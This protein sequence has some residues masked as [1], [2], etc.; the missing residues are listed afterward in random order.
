MIYFCAQKARRASVLEHPNL[1]GIDFLEV[2]LDHPTQLNVVF[3]KPD[4]LA[5]LQPVEFAISGGE[6]VSGI[7]AESLTI[8]PDMLNRAVVTVNEGG[9]FSTYTLTLRHLPAIGDPKV[10]GPPDGFDPALARIDFS[11]KAGCPTT[12]DCRI[13]NCCPV[14]A[15]SGPD[16][17]YLAKDFQGFRQVMLDR[18]WTL[19]PGWTEQHA[20][21]PGIALVEALAY[22]ADHLSYRHD[23]IGTESYL[24]TARSRISLRRHAR[25]VDYVVSDG[26]CAHTWLQIQ[27][28]LNSGSASLPINTPVFSRVSG[29]PG[30]VDPDSSDYPTLVKNSA[31]AFTTLAEKMCYELHNE[32]SFYTWSDTNCCLPAGAVEA[33]LCGTLSKLLVGDVLIFAEQFGPETGQQEDADPTHRWAVRLTGVRSTDYLG[34]VLTDPLTGTAVTYIEWGAADALPF[35]L[36]VSSTYDDGKAMTPLPNVSVAY[37]N[38][39]IARHGAQ[40]IG[41]WLGVVPAATG[42][43]VGTTLGYCCGTAAQTAPLPRYNPSLQHQP[44]S[45]AYP[46]DAGAAAST[47]TVPG[48]PSATLAPP[49][50]LIS[51][52]D[53]QK[54]PW[55]PQQTLLGMDE[56]TP[57]FVVEVE[58]DGT[59]FLRFGDGQSGAAALPNASFTAS[60]WTGNGTAGNVG[61]DTLIHLVSKTEAF[62]S[63]GNPLAAAGGVDPETM[64]HIRQT[65]P[66]A[67]RTQMRAVTEDDYGEVALRD[68]RIKAARGTFRWTGSWRTTFVTLDPAVGQEADTSLLAETLTRLDLFRMAGTD[69]A[70]EPAII[71]GLKIVLHVCVDTAHFRSDVQKALLRLLISG[72]TCDGQSGLLAPVNFTLGE[73]VYLSPIVAAVQAVEGVAS[74]NPLAFQRLDDPTSDA[75]ATGYLTMNRLE[76]ASVAND[77][78]RL[79]L[80]YLTL[81]LDGGK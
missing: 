32:L 72:N 81:T 52:V 75:S 48:P 60:Y 62:Q 41:E 26:S 23:A 59:A 43:P 66:V 37:G 30:R 8:T 70:V 14:P 56:L 69:L 31:A 74:M 35:P 20:A 36:C 13:D 50:P 28:A 55:Y 25:L 29:L 46:P 42:S 7:V 76:L 12:G 38:V 5:A 24:G 18:M 64:D 3:L 73:T 51:L 44:L 17:N 15:A 6:T 68:T 34:R 78:N 49:P 27:L 45:F 11:F 58:R 53:D 65:A 77:P 19:L 2:S 39:V 10:D 71:V 63:V 61:R 54:N 80:G 40:Q 22:V 57:G 33:T 79:D 21:D 9:D 67:F 4:G 1:N 47:V 16:I